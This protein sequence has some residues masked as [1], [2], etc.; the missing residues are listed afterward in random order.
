MYNESISMQTKNPLLTRFYL[1]AVGKSKP[2]QPGDGHVWAVRLHLSIVGHL[3]PDLLINSVWRFLNAKFVRHWAAK[4]HSRSSVIVI[5]DLHVYT[6]V[7]LTAVPCV[8]AEY[9]VC[10]LHCELLRSPRCR[11][12]IVWIW[13]F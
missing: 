11:A 13:D 3:R 5:C 6:D 12:T 4:N 7:E 10:N 9:L 2:D 8:R 1:F